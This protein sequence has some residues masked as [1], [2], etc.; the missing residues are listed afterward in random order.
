MPRGSNY[1]MWKGDSS[2]NMGYT[3]EDVIRIV[4]EEDV[5]F[6]RLQ[7]TDIFGQLKNV[8]ITASQIEKAV[9][10]QCMFDGS[11][12]E[13]FVRINESDQYLYPDL[14]SFRIFPWRPSH[15]KVARLI[16]DVYNPDGSPFVGDPRQVLKKV[17]QKANDMGYD[18]FNV[19]PELEFF[20]FQTDEEGKP[21]TKTNDEAGYFDLGPLDHGESTRREIC[22]ALEQMDF[23]I[24]AS[25]HEV[26]QGQHEI[27][28]KYAE[29]LHA[30]DNIMT[31][32]LAVK[33]LAQKN[34]LHA[35]FMPKP[36]FGINGSGMHTNMSLFRNGKNVFY[37][38]DGEKGLSKEAYSFIA[39]ILAHM[40]GMAAIP[41]PL[42]NS[43]KR[44]VPGYEAPCY[45]AWSASNRSALIRIPAARGQSTR[46]E[47]RCPDP[48]C[49]PYLAL[50][51]CLAAGLD[52]IEK[53][54]TPPPEITDN[55]F[56]MTPAT[57]KRRGIEALPGSLEEA[58]VCMKKDK[59]IMNPLGDHVT[60][61]YIAGKEAE[62][63]EYRTRVSSWER[64]K[65]MINY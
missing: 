46:V 38:P 14:K 47:L 54:M 56:A 51:V 57:R 30:A 40:K 1:K 12:I 3:K 9:N 24:E 15:G 17:I 7:F 21:T 22:L 5:K 25:H 4:K 63:D 61:Q 35:T 13:G 23:E 48:S 34:G 27:D 49:N 64:D 32:K 55:I 33:T 60:S 42:V 11:S 19:G 50:A 45:M 44:L 6:I 8:A 37:D 58:L 16:C 10:N 20:L 53:G 39:G 59:L 52:G 31:F 36:I 41:N 26:A 65:Y 62:W 43:Y 18:R 29:A 2:M 28:F